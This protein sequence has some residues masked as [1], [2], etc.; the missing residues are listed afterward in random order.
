MWVIFE[1]L[2]KSGKTT[3]E[4]AFL[5][6]TNYE[7]IVVDRGPVGYMVFDKIFKRVGN[8]RRENFIKQAKKVMKSKDFVI[9]YCK[10]PYEVAQ[11]RL[12]E[13]N[14]ECPYD[15]KEAQKLYD[16]YVSIFY[17]KRYVIELDTTK[18]IDECVDLII[19]KLEGVSKSEL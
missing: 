6:K 16:N 1:G 10:A 2:D 14:E 3:L 15:Y 8:N 12:K 4:Y 13:H 19:K 5:K 9:V 11:E 18:S 17:S 7:H